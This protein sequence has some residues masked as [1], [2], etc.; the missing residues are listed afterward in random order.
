M[1]PEPHTLPRV[2]A[3]QE[4]GSRAH[5][6]YLFDSHHIR[7]A[8]GWAGGSDGLEEYEIS[9]HEVSPYQPA[10]VGPD[11]E[12]HPRAHRIHVRV[13]D[14]HRR[15]Y[16]DFHYRTNHTVTWRPTGGAVYMLSSQLPIPIIDIDCDLPCTERN[17]LHAPPARRQDLR[18]WWEHWNPGRSNLFRPL[19]P[20]GRGSRPDSDEEEEDSEEERQ[21][22]R[23]QRRQQR[24]AA[25]AAA[26]A[27]VAPP[28]PPIPKFVA[29]ALIRDAI[30][31]AATCPITME[32]LKTDTTAVTACFHLFERDAIAVWL[33]QSGDC[34]AVC[35]Q[36]TTVA[37][38]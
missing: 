35:K 12:S 3:V 32:P 15:P 4:R 37:V 11:R 36:R 2:F 27:P 23:Q 29:E 34:C 30:T 28:P 20:Q 8:H 6:V 19:P 33:A 1:T 24:V 18:I 13:E 10:A 22:R 38:V 9:P 14:W 25:A 16:N 21:R 5:T 31:R 17:R 7:D 26:P